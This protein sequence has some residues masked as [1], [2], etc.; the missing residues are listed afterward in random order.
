MVN[1]SVYLLTYIPT[2]FPGLKRGG[3]FALNNVKKTAQPLDW[4]AGFNKACKKTE[5]QFVSKLIWSYIISECADEKYTMIL[6]AI[7]M[8]L[9]LLGSQYHCLEASDFC[10]GCIRKGIKSK[11]TANFFVE[12]HSNKQQTHSYSTEPKH[13]K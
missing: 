7:Q 12:A 11:T 2:L 5:I 4:K 1:E 6:L 8:G 10:P 13:G 9:A 3:H